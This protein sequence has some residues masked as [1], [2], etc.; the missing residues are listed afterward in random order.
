[1][2]KAMVTTIS[3]TVF[4]LLLII[5]WLPALIARMGGTRFSYL[6]PSPVP[7]PDPL[8]REPDYEF[9][10]TQ[11]RDLGYELIGDVRLQMD[12]VENSWRINSWHRLFYSPEKT[13]HVLVQKFPQPFQIWRGVEFISILN[14]DT[15][16][17]TKNLPP[18]IVPDDPSFVLQGDNTFILAD[19][20]KTHLDTLEAA[21]RSGRRPE[22]E[23]GVDK[24]LS[25]M[26]RLENRTAKQEAE[27]LAGKYL[28]VNFIIHVCVS[29]PTA[30]AMSFGHWSLAV[31]NIVLLGVMQLGDSIQKN[32]MGTM[33]RES[34]RSVVTRR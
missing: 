3:W 14:D 2:D 24:I 22:T 25:G 32:Q 28:S 20:E 21:R 27:R 29:I 9:W 11:L 19:L 33:M 16:V 23:V 6:G 18:Q 8:E 13:T 1:M 34:L 12:F 15:I 7:E 26:E 5:F 4:G 31:T 30:Y 10:A 17:V